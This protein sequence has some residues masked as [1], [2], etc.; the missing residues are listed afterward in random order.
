MLK[1]FPSQIISVYLFLGKWL[2][3]FQEFLQLQAAEHINHGEKFSN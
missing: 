2:H 1:I 3:K